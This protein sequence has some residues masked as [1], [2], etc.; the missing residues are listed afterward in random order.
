[1]V[2]HLAAVPG[3]SQHREGLL[4]DHYLAPLPH[5]PAAVRERHPYPEEAGQRALRQEPRLQD[6][7]EDHP[8]SHPL[9]QVC[10]L[11]LYIIAYHLHVSTIHIRQQV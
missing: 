10:H 7:A 11:A 3:S 9:P 4:C 8:T 5:G 1:M 2:G 6:L